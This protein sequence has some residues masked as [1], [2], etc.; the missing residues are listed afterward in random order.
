[1]DLVIN[2][3]DKYIFDYIYPETWAHSNF[4]RQSLSLWLIVVLGAY[5]LYFSISS[6]DFFVLYDKKNLNDR[7]ILKNQIAKEIACCCWS[8]PIMG[9]YSLP[10]YMVSGK[11]IRN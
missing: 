7:R 3:A 9:M 10:F 2:L 8:I 5:L 1:M 6:L 11:K 4:W